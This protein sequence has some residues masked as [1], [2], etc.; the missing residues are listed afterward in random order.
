MKNYD[1]ND[2][3]NRYNYREEDK[4]KKKAHNLLW[5]LLLLCFFMVA[6]ITVII[7][8]ITSAW[9]SFTQKMEGDF[10]FENGIVMT[11][12]DIS[13]QGGTNFY[14]LKKQ[15]SNY[16]S[17]NETNVRFDDRYEI[18]NP[19]L[20]AAEGSVDFLLRAKLNYT[21][22]KEI[23]GVVQ[24]LNLQQLANALNAEQGT[25][26]YNASN[27]LSAIYAKTLSFSNKWLDGG[28]GWFYYVGNLSNWTNSTHSVNYNDISGAA[29]T[30]DTEKIEV[31]E[32]NPVIEVIPGEGN[33][34][35]TFLVKSCKV[36]LIIN[37]CEVTESAFESWILG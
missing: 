29:V 23:D 11:Y 30:K 37:A 28:D 13:V 31:F 5:L 21:F 27:V 4:K 26:E 6:I 36:T 18:V 10:A 8:G 3:K 16:S 2:M 20:S 32:T 35:E 17:L 34:M 25:T 12:E 24:E 1:S 15:G 33:D 22:T 19:K 9:F 7:V 14:L